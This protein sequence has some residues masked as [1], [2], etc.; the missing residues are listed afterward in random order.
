MNFRIVCATLAISI[1]SHQVIAETLK[2]AVADV[3]VMN[4]PSTNQPIVSL[5]LTPESRTA[6][7][8]FTKARIGERVKMRLGDTV[9][10]EPF[11]LEPIVAG[12]L[13][14]TGGL[15]AGSARALADLIV[16]SGRTFEVDGSDK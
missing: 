3:E 1:F 13:A 14:V 10:M 8:E 2:V 15:T 7:A 9:L 6:I 4:D 12:R 5:T 16:K 11:I